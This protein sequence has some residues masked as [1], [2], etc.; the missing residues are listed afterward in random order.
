MIR[1][2]T[3]GHRLVRRAMR[4]AALV[5]VAAAAWGA[6]AQPPP[7]L[8][9]IRQTWGT[10]TRSNRGLAIAAVDPK[11]HAGPDHRW[12]VY[13]SR[14]EDVARGRDQLRA[15]MKP[16]DLSRIEIRPLPEDV[17]HIREQGLLYL[18]RPYVVPGGRFNE[19]YGWDSFF[20]QLG[21][22]RD[23]D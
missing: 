8:D 20:I 3:G 2:D 23:G 11:M 17:N 12:P 1:T 9:Y 21:L 10:L 14:T 15:E 5:L 13:I 18:P 4:T 22:L 16:E 7:I 6:T 19:M